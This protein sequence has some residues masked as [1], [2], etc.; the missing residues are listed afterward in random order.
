MFKRKVV[1]GIHGAVMTL[2]LYELSLIAMGY[3]Q[4]DSNFAR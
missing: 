3:R 2:M 1:L 4:Q